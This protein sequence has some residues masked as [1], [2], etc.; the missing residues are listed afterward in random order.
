MFDPTAFENMKVVLEGA[1]YDLDITG[2]IIITDRNDWINTAKLSRK[3]DIYFQLPENPVTAKL[4]LDSSLE[5]LAAEL[6]PGYASD[7]LSGCYINLEFS[8]SHQ[9]RIVDYKKVEKVLLDIWGEN[10]KV[11]QSVTFYPLQ[12]EKIMTSVA[13]VKFDR[14][15]YEDQM[16]DLVDMIDVMITTLEQLSSFL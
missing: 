8:F 13:S 2:D 11:I 16:N 12:K 9:Q 3:F 7:I 4:E 6:L 5:N 14:I 15:I 1:L 10:R